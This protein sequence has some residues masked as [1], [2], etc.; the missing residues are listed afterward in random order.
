MYSSSC[1]LHWRWPHAEV[2]TEQL[3]HDRN[4]RRYGEVSTHHHLSLQRWH[5][6]LTSIQ[7]HPY[8]QNLKYNNCDVEY[9]YCSECT[10]LKVKRQDS[11]PLEIYIKL[12]TEW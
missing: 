12:T 11:D 9:Y 1:P 6:M 4:Y 2:T 8:G 10:V 5:R 3:L 7:Q